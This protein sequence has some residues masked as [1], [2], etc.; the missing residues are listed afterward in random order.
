MED[1][2][3]KRDYTKFLLSW[4]L[5]YQ[6]QLS[7]AHLKWF[8]KNL[9]FYFERRIL[10]KGDF[11]VSGYKKK[12]CSSHVPSRTTASFKRSCKPTHYFLSVGFLLF[13][14]LDVHCRQWSSVEMLWSKRERGEYDP[15]QRWHSHPH[16]FS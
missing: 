12:A 10:G 2:K 6:S 13:V 3:C 1:W 4:I 14:L 16:S 7:T 15:H 11:A 5:C 8:A 9:K